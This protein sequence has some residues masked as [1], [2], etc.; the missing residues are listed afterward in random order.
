MVATPSPRRNQHDYLSSNNSS[1]KLDP[2]QEVSNLTRQESALTDAHS[3]DG[4][5]GSDGETFSEV[6]QCPH[7]PQLLEKL[8]EAHGDDVAQEHAGLHPVVRAAREENYCSNLVVGDLTKNPSLNSHF[9]RYAL[10]D[11]FNH[12]GQRR[13]QNLSMSF[14]AKQHPDIKSTFGSSAATRA[15]TV[16][17]VGMKRSPHLSARAYRL[18]TEMVRRDR[19]AIQ[20]RNLE[21][22]KNLETKEKIQLEDVQKRQHEMLF[23][24]VAN[25]ERYLPNGVTVE[26]LLPLEV[27]RIQQNEEKKRFEKLNNALLDVTIKSK[28]QYQWDRSR[29]VSRSATMGGDDNLAENEVA[30]PAEMFDFMKQYWNLRC[31]DISEIVNNISS[32][33]L[34]AGLS[35]SMGVDRSVFCR[36]LIDVGIVDQDTVPYVWAVRTFD[37]YARHVRVCNVV[38]NDL[39]SAGDQ[40]SE[41]KT[42]VAPLVCKLDFVT[43]IDVVLRRRFTRGTLPEFL[44]MLKRIGSQMNADWLRKEQEANAAAAE[45]SKGIP[46]SEPSLF[47]KVFSGAVS[48]MGPPPP[49]NQPALAAVTSNMMFGEEAANADHST[50]RNCASESAVWKRNRL[51]SGMLAEPE[52]LQLVEQ[53][54]EVFQELFN[55]YTFK[56]DVNSIKEEEN[57]TTTPQS[58]PVEMEFVDFVQFCQDLSI[59]PRLASMYDVQ[60]AFRN[61]ECL[62]FPEEDRRSQSAS[63]PGTPKLPK[64]L[65]EAE[66]LVDLLQKFTA[67]MCEKFGHLGPAFSSFDILGRERL[68]MSDVKAGAIKVGFQGDVLKVWRELDVNRSGHITRQE[69][70]KLQEY[71]PDVLPPHV[72][73][74]CEVCGNSVLPD[75][76]FCRKCGTSV[77]RL[78]DFNEDTV[79]D[80]GK[81][82]HT[83]LKPKHRGTNQ[84]AA[85]PL[86]MPNRSPRPSIL[87]HGKTQEFAAALEAKRRPQRES[88]GP[89]Q[90]AG[91]LARSESRAD[92][93][94]EKHGET[95]KRPSRGQRKPSVL[96]RGYGQP[97]SHRSS[98]ERCSPPAEEKKR[99]A[100]P[101]AKLIVPT[102]GVAAFVETLCRIALT[103]L[104]VHG[105]NVQVATSARAKIVW[106]LAYLQTVL[107]HLRES[108]GR[109]LNSQGDS[110]QGRKASRESVPATPVSDRQS[111]S[112]RCSEGGRSGTKEVTSDLAWAWGSGISRR[113][114]RTLE[115]VTQHTFKAHAI[116]E[117]QLDRH[118]P[119]VVAPTEKVEEQKE[120]AVEPPSDKKDNHRI[121][122]RKS[123]YK[124]DLVASAAM[125]EELGQAKSPES[126][127]TSRTASKLAS[128]APGSPRAKANE[129][130][131]GPPREA[132]KS[133]FLSGWATRQLQNRAAVAMQKVQ[134]ANSRPARSRTK[135]LN[136]MNSNPL[137]VGKDVGRKSKLGRNGTNVLESD[138]E[139]KEENEEQK[140]MQKEVF[141]VKQEPPSLQDDSFKFGNLLF[142]RLL[143]QHSPGRQ[144]RERALRAAADASK[145]FGR[146]NT[147][148]SATSTGTGRDTSL[149]AGLFSPGNMTPVSSVLSGFEPSSPRER[150]ASQFTQ[151]GESPVA[152]E[153]TLTQNKFSE[154]RHVLRQGLG[155]CVGKL[156][157][158]LLTPP[159]LNAYATQ[160]NER[161]ERMMSGAP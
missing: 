112:S 90:T 1:D 26:E 114:E 50:S 32:W 75:A 148:L 22:Y 20:Q 88:S 133:V 127:T 2:A 109:R 80:A 155:G 144:E 59:V 81:D 136:E 149:G 99:S 77:K 29:P 4:S 107:E 9:Q 121:K 72:E 134:K 119:S 71:I 137:K 124:M 92:E 46:A 15:A 36:F 69:W 74:V 3:T 84:L 100:S 160:L 85:L 30:A 11:F 126:A 53:Y 103:Y 101:P 94:D 35:A 139:L 113:L 122:R 128:E 37:Q 123:R 154:D 31:D 34:A 86:Q 106:L 44:E 98:L 7:S 57:S 54:R 64:P 141:A 118:M 145:G 157:R 28:A 96:P 79:K 131:E 116:M 5:S 48:A 45:R 55:C 17:F 150:P 104:I 108:H 125:V 58:A 14:A 73:K 129:E 93:P 156:E 135:D 21:N 6:P 43:V 18:A 60:R 161:L 23:L 132:S 83:P 61:A 33:T 138:L 87:R 49:K 25:Y 152:E 66:K 130:A 68:T 42:V 117:L 13:Y 10:R 16:G 82:S 120:K 102:F 8:L 56:E 19:E 151:Q 105:N 70:L 110:S 89:N 91:G 146:P 41:T 51:I 159:P 12:R 67:L 158:C 78:D 65:T 24:E 143:R 52:V 27:S 63:E 62:D 111:M 76:A 115:R 40:W 39:Y 38:E 97:H 142:K 153:S 140:K 47:E 147:T 95:P